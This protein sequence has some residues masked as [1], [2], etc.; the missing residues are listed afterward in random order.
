[1]D[2]EE[3]EVIGSIEACVQLW[4]NWMEQVSDEEYRDQPYGTGK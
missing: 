4:S 2:A 3:V 1:L